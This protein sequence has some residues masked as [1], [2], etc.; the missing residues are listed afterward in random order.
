MAD[1]QIATP[2]ASQIKPVQG[3]S[4]GEMMNFA[5]G[6]QAYQ[7]GDIAL[8]LEQQKQK[9]RQGVTDWMQ[10]PENWQTDGRMDINKVNAGLP[11]IAP[12]TGADWITKLT[13][14]GQSQ[15]QA[16]KAIQDM[17]TSQREVVSSGLSALGYQGAK[18]PAVYQ[19]FL[20]N[21]EKQYQNIPSMKNLVQSF[22]TQLG[23]VS[24]PESLPQLAIGAANQMMT[25]PT[26]QQLLAPTV[27]TQDGRTVITQPSVAGGTPK[28]TIGIAGGIQ[29]APATPSTPIAGTQ[30]APGMRVPYPVRSASQ[31][32]IPEPSEASD[33]TAGEAYRTSLVNRQSNLVTDRRNVEEALKTAQN[34]E[35]QLYRKEG[36]VLQNIE[37]SV[38]MAINSDE[39]KLLSKDLANL[40]ISNMRALG[41]VGNTVAG[42]D[43]T[44][45]AN[46]DETIPPKVLQQIIRRTQADM[47]N[48]DMQAK[49]AQ[50]FKQQYGDNNMKAFQQAWNANADS[51][52]FEAMNIVRDIDDPVQRNKELN[53]LFPSQKLHSEFLTKYRNLK[54]LSETGGL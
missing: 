48:I 27:T 26:Q 28:A 18:D 40:Q 4:L 19:N 34:L 13:T 38:R 17:T 41:N 25:A 54:K 16:E 39:Y 6:A 47:T 30:I 37:R 20:D 9:E 1:L 45:V 22:R 11:K 43:L 8:S 35:S 50:I 51:K 15:T 10:N 14:L 36:G 52:I 32:Y 44:R 12:L 53:K 5:R 33:Q 3:M 21:V 31:P 24:N 29:Q 49:G 2:V 23:M 42:I 7:T 46:G